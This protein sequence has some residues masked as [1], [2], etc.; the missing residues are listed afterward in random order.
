MLRLNHE[1]PGPQNPLG[2]VGNRRRSGGWRAG[3]LGGAGLWLLLGGLAS[4]EPPAP[5]PAPAAPAATAAK[6]GAARKAPAAASAV[7]PG[8]A[9]GAAPGDSG[10]AG[11]AVAAQKP[12]PRPVLDPQRVVPA[13]WTGT[14]TGG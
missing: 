1:W 6:D 5:V 10:R 2:P 14:P 4:A 3:L 12:K 13:T 11:E 7:A 9:P 8:A